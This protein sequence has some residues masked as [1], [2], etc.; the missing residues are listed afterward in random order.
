MVSEGRMRRLAVVLAF[1]NLWFIFPT[2]LVVDV[3]LGWLWASACCIVL[4][5]ATLPRRS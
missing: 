1:L 3:A 2:L 4:T 5:V